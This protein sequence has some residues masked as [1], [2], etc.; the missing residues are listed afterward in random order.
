MAAMSSN[1]FSVAPSS[2]LSGPSSSTELLLKVNI[3]ARLPVRKKKLRLCS[4]VTKHVSCF[5]Y[6][7][8][9]VIA[10]EQ[11]LIISA[12]GRFATS[13]GEVCRGSGTYKCSTTPDPLASFR[14]SRPRTFPQEKKH[15]CRS[16]NGEALLH[17]SSIIM[18]AV[19]TLFTRYTARRSAGRPHRTHTFIIIMAAGSFSTDWPTKTFHMIRISF[20]FVAA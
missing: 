17:I 3:L 6:Y 2:V 15:S 8:S 4:W 10:Y 9:S 5:L 7:F 12:V 18:A 13:Q 16:T 19:T 11:V 14:C 1:S 20:I